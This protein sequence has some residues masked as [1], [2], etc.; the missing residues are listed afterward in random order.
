MEDRRFYGDLAHNLSQDIPNQLKDKQ[1]GQEWLETASDQ[2]ISRFRREKFSG[3]ALVGESIDD[4]EKILLIR[5]Q[6]LRRLDRLLEAKLLDQIWDPSRLLQGL[7]G[8]E[9]Y[10]SIHTVFVRFSDIHLLTKHMVETLLTQKSLSERARKSLG[11]VLDVYQ[12]IF[13]AKEARVKAHMLAVHAEKEIR[14]KFKN[15]IEQ[16]NQLDTKAAKL[17]QV[18]LYRMIKGLWP[19]FA[20]NYKLR[21]VDLQADNFYSNGVLNKN[22]SPFS[23]V[24]TRSV[25]QAPQRSSLLRSQSKAVFCS[26]SGASSSSLCIS[27]SFFELVSPEESPQSIPRILTSSL[28][29][30]LLSP[31]KSLI[32]NFMAL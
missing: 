10:K 19:E 17:Y 8:Y 15:E 16:R 26:G 29:G 1:L 5:E 2:P 31:L 18:L 4:S 20:V 32:A 30:S 24:Y 9:K 6:R 13:K 22:T 11:H 14:E 12:Q 27:E 23:N 3:V 7:L 25:L 28:L 21:E